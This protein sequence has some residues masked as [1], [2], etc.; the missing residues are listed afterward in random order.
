M[1]LVKGD[2]GGGG[3]GGS[4]CICPYLNTLS[5]TYNIQYIIHIYAVG[6]PQKKLSLMAGPLRPN[7]PPP[8]SLMGVEILEGW[9]KGSKKSFFS[10]MARPFTPSPLLMA[11]PLREELFLRLPLGEK[12]KCPIIIVKLSIKIKSNI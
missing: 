4:R 12:Q 1:M 11:L 5:T 10:I 3:K 8:S 6:K 2:G 7:P 9:K